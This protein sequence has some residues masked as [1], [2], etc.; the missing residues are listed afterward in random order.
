MKIKKLE[1]VG[2]KS[3][4]DRTVINFDHDVTGIVGPNGCG[5]S[6]VVD[7]IKWVQGEQSASRL[8]GKAM[9]D[10]IF[11]GCESR[12]PHGFAEVSLTFA[13]DDGLAPPEYREYAEIKVT[14]RL[15]RS[16]KSDYRINGAAV[17]LMDI[18][19]LFLGTGVGRR[20]Y[21]I[22]EQGRIGYIVSSKP[23]D[24]RAIIEEAAGITKFKIRKQAAERKMDAT[25]Q[26]L[27]RVT[28][29]IGEL[30]RN[31]KSLERQAQKA[32]RYKNYRAEQRD[33]EL[34]VASF[35]YLELFG[36]QKVV[37]HRLTTASDTA[38]TV[39]QALRV[40][41]A[42]I[43]ARRAEL[44]LVSTEVEEAQ[45]ESYRL[46]NE[47]RALEGEIKQQRQ[48]LEDYQEREQTAARDLEEVTAQRAGLVDERDHLVRALEEAES[49]EEEAA[50][51]L[52][53]END[54]LM[55]RRTAVEEAERAVNNARARVTDAQTRIARAEAV[56]AG[57]QRRKNE[58]QARLNKLRDERDD[59][60][61]RV[62]EL[63]Q[64]RSELDAR[65]DGLRSGREQTA[66][67]KQQVEDE[68]VALREER[69]ACDADVEQL[70]E[71]L[72]TKRSRL[73]SLQE[74]QQRFEGVGAGVRA[75]MTRF[76]DNDQERAARGVL[77]LVADRVESDDQYTRALAAA[78]GDKLQHI[79][80]DGVDAG[81]EA[82]GFL[83]EAGKGRAALVP[84]TP[85]HQA[86]QTPAVHGPGVLGR[87]VDRLRFAPEDRA[88]IEHLLGDVTVVN[89]FDEAIAL[90]RSQPAHGL[91][92]TLSGERIEADGTIM[93]GAED[94]SGAH[95]LSMKR[96]MRQLDVEVADLTARWDARVARQGELRTAI[97]QRQAEMDSARTAAHDAEIAIVS[98][99]KDLRN[100]EEE[101][102]RARRRNEDV[103]GEV[104]DLAYNLEQAEDEER[105]SQREIEGARDTE[106]EAEQALGAQTN[107]LEDRRYAVEEQSARVTE[108]RVRAA[109]AKERAEGDRNAVDRLERSLTELTHRHERLAAEIL[110]ASGHQ[111]R[112]K[113]LIMD[114]VEGLSV[115]TEQAMRA[116]EVLAEVRVRY[117]AAQ[118][119]MGH[120]E[121]ELKEL[122]AQ[123]EA[124]GSS[125]N[126]L[127]IR[128][129]EL[130]LAISHL[131]ES[132]T[133]RHEVNLPKIL[134]D[135]HA[136]ELPDATMLLRID[137]LQK[138]I[139][140]MGE[141]NLMAIE[142]FE[143]KNGRFQYMAGQR[144]DLEDALSQ[145]ERAIR[146][147]NKQS[148]EMFKEAFLSINE[149]FKRIYP[150]MFRGGKAELKLTDPDNILES[151]VDII[152][153]P[154]GK[155]LGSLELM[156]GGEKALT[157]V[158]LIFA[159]FQYKPSPFCILDEVD[160]P[161]DEA[162]I[163][164]FA[165]A[166]R[167]MTARSQ[168]IVITH[169]KRTMEYTDVLYGV[170]M[171]QAGISKLVAVELRGERSGMMEVPAAAVA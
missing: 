123:I 128:S 66:E 134:T 159:I 157:A 71:E 131:L 135:Y 79:V 54:E 112:V 62:M 171:E 111:E 150:E 10:V 19:N 122:R 132:V 149:R 63:A 99:E 18:T 24:R 31:L 164:R 80:V 27:L 8:R 142:E 32:E 38:D 36:E 98:I 64:S 84:R 58:A 37:A 20:A 52:E 165:Q 125:V 11:N 49:A 124:V 169:S 2:F 94:D 139:S 45:R 167:Q 88:L 114:A 97:A 87:L 100:I 23:A 140:R 9:D 74:L 59:L 136:R 129:R 72:T 61:G 68:L 13:N 12:G 101:S 104:E 57:F 14:R 82:I 155:R 44:Q 22:I 158:A 51:V 117:D 106:L 83:R 148:R 170:T 28:D 161:L 116:Q 6:N 152:A 109:Q 144:A 118:E 15:D 168:F 156:S 137:E 17:R 56:S 29:I 166:I 153:Q 7:A 89:S 42:E 133:E 81:L 3:F 16:G 40:R 141:I 160:A 115:S 53:V 102:S 92:V 5:K 151:G 143:E 55:R 85:R 105:E 43:E 1:I 41:E 76:A 60:A 46:D 69:V 163:S 21:S 86:T 113:G 4:V 39:R 65:L 67:R 126:E 119:E 47:V 35:R 30:E 78:L 48:R 50:S 138:L 96:E 107:V 121:V 110:A 130:E 77:G 33:L 154:P 162:N 26:N 25:R 91:L 146:Q 75:L 103:A 127:K 108:V 34:H 73:R 120:H 90:H 70:R 145:L 95:M 93:G 147:M